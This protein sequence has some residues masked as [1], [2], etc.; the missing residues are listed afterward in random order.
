MPPGESKRGD[1]VALEPDG[2]WRLAADALPEP[3]T[4]FMRYAGASPT[5]GGKLLDGRTWE[6]FPR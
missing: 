6:E 4:A 3:E 5:A 2:R 1:D